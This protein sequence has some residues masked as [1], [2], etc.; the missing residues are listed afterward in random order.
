MN[1]TISG[2]YQIKNLSNGKIYVGCSK[3]IYKRW[4]QHKSNLKH[5][6]HSNVALQ[7]D[8]NDNAK[9]SFIFEVLEIIDDMNELFIRENEWIDR[10]NTKQYE[11][12][13][14]NYSNC[15][16][17]FNIDEH[18]ANM[19]DND[20]NFDDFIADDDFV[21]LVTGTYIN[22]Y[23]CELFTFEEYNKIIKCKTEKIKMNQLQR[24]IDL[25]N[26]YKK[27]AIELC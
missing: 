7:T 1:T 9:D 18:F 6:K 13:Y 14:N 12:G 25:I 27:E 10:L 3:N 23:S 5:N 26:K 2:I 20:A 15:D 24:K 17:K 21:L 16:Y 19:E 8:Y 11:F 4:Q 22:I